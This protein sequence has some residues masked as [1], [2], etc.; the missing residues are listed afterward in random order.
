MSWSIVKEWKYEGSKYRLVQHEDRF[1]VEELVQPRD[2]EWCWGLRWIRISGN[3]S[4]WQ[5][6][7]CWIASKEA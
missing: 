3:M 1:A 7:L 2:P 5:R 4:P 6:A